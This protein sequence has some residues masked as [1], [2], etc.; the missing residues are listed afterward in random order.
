MK[1][2]PATWNA[3]LDFA[4][5]HFQPPPAFRV[6]YQIPIEAVRNPSRQAIG[7]T[8]RKWNGQLGTLAEVDE[9]APFVIGQNAQ[10]VKTRR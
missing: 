10:R 1:S 2:N 7:A 3:Q 8:K 4:I 9:A 5:H 6:V